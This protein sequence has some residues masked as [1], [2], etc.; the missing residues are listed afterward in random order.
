MLKVKT[1]LFSGQT[2]PFRSALRS[3]TD[4]GDGDG[5]VLSRKATAQ[6]NASRRSSERVSELLD[7]KAKA[8]YSVLSE[9]LQSQQTN[10]AGSDYLTA[11]AHCKMNLRSAAAFAAT[12]SSDCNLKDNDILFSMQSSH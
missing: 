2:G 4:R 8:G 7:A 1:S 9:Y 11:E 12:S 6:R 5:D 3:E 10:L